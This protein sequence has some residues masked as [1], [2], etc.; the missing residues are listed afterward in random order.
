MAKKKKESESGEHT[1]MP[2]Y[3]PFELFTFSDVVLKPSDFNVR[4]VS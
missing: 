3:F 1:F 4:S 2:F